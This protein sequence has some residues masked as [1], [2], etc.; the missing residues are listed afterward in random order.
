[1][2][3][4]FWDIETSPGIYY[5]WRSG[6][7]IFIPHDNQLE[8]AKIICICY[9]WEGEKKVHHLKWELEDDH[10]M[11]V[12]FSFVA[13]QAD[14]MVAHNGDNFDLK[15]FNSRNALNGFPPLPPYKTVDTY[16][17]AKNH[18]KFDSNKLD[19]LAFI[20][21]GKKKIKTDFELWKQCKAGKSKALKEMI[22]YCKR[23]VVL[24]E[25]V[26]QVLAPYASPKTHVGVLHGGGRWTCPYCG[27][28]S[29]IKSK[30]RPTRMGM[31]RHQMQCK[32]CGAY[33]TVSDLVF[34][35]YKEAK[36][37]EVVA[38]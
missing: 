2:K 5:S 7:K 3:R 28:E 30:T 12:E 6:S 8:E 18:F 34:R 31:T 11:I 29:V 33:N 24:L 15:W 35:Q 22:R 37:N 25:Q 10:E 17:I 26:Y 4:L 23:D 32:D 13:D 36:Y 20:F 38:A 19:A 16:K 14:E 1:M 27:S 9:K 21:L